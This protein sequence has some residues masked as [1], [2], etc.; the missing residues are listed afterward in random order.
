MN[1][2]AVKIADVNQVFMNCIRTRN[3]NR[4]VDL[5][6]EDAILLANNAPP[7]VGHLGAARFFVMLQEKGISEVCLTTIEIEVVGSCAWERGSSEAV[8]EI[9]K[10]IGRGNYVVIW[11]QTS[12]GWKL[13]R[14]VMNT[15]P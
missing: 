5:Y 10:V 1:D 7:M 14:D 9:G 13:H 11:K 15:A 2:A 3:L 8:N 6:T 12:L 4:F